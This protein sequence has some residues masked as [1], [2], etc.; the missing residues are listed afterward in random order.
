MM[1]EMMALARKAG[2]HDVRLEFDR[3]N[4]GVVRFY[5]KLGFIPDGMQAVRQHGP[6]AQHHRPFL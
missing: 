1:V 4:E 6:A 2:M 5:E 3:S